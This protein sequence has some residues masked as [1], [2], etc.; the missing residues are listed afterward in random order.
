MLLFVFQPLPRTEAE[1]K[2]VI[3]IYFL[4]GYLMYQLNDGRYWKFYKNITGT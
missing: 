4:F 2:E 3:F 1:L